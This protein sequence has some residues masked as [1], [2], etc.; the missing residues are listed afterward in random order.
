MSNFQTYALIASFTSQF[1][2]S[3]LATISL[4]SE[5]S[6]IRVCS[7]LV[8]PFSV[9]YPWS[10]ILL[11]LS[12]T[13]HR[14]TCPNGECLILFAFVCLTIYCPFINFS[15]SWISSLLDSASDFLRGP[16]I[17]L[18]ISLSKSSQVFLIVACEAHSIVV[19]WI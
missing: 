13:D 18:T 3:L 9:L 19:Y 16:E 4:I 11:N 7:G 17:L 15:V 2:F 5:L 6:T 10:I 12:S 1:H 8:L 14:F